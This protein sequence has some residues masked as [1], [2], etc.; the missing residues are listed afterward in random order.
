MAK[1]ADA[2]AGRPEKLSSHRFEPASV[3]KTVCFKGEYLSIAHEGERHEPTKV[4]NDPPT[5][6]YAEYKVPAGY[7][8]RVIGATVYFKD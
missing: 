3:D 6:Q 4:D 8:C 1:G 5:T 7:A 2:L